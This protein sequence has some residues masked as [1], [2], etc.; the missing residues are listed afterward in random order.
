MLLFSCNV[1]TIEYGTGTVDA[2]SSDMFLGTVHIKIGSAVISVMVG[3]NGATPIIIESLDDKPEYSMGPNLSYCTMLFFV[4][5]LVSWGL[6][7][8]NFTDTFFNL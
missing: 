7:P 8:I 1:F 6:R 4:L 2:S 5:T 3:T